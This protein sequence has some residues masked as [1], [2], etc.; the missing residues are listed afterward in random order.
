MTREGKE[1]DYGEMSNEEYLVGINEMLKRVESNR[2][3]RY[4]YIYISEKMRRAR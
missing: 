1:C 3:L 4:F 2:I